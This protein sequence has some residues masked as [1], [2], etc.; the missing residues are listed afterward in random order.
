MRIFWTMAA[1][2]LCCVGSLKGAYGAEEHLG[3][4][5]QLYFEPAP[6]LKPP[7]DSVPRHISA[8]HVAR[9][10]IDFSYP[11]TAASTGSHIAHQETHRP[12]EESPWQLDLTD[13]AKLR[14]TYD[15]DTKL[16]LGMGMWKVKV[17]VSRA[18]GGPSTDTWELPERHGRAAALGRADNS[19][20]RHPLN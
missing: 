17:G 16:K 18:F 12:R 1:A 3:L 13:G 20:N 5:G 14:F 11:E 19:V 7:Q 6:A 9:A 15:E 2:M 4:R 10:P 8:K